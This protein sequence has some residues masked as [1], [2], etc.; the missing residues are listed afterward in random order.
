MIEQCISPVIVLSLASEA[1]IAVANTIVVHAVAIVVRRTIV[2]D[3]AVVPKCTMI[4]GTRATAN[5]IT[6]IVT[7][8]VAGKAIE[9]A[10]AS[11][12]RSIVVTSVT[13]FILFVCVFFHST[14]LVIVQG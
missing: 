12:K 13:V 3:A 2:E 5:S 7:I 11:G 4:M 10:V 8:D 6:T 9:G 14:I 1:T